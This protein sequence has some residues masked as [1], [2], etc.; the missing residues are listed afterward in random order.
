MKAL[1]L[2]AALAALAL[3]VAC[4]KAAPEEAE[5][6]AA[7][8]VEV[9]VARLGTIT[10]YVRATGTIDPDPLEHFTP[11]ADQRDGQRVD[12]DLEGQ[13]DDAVGVRADERRGPAGGTRRRGN[14]LDDEATGHEFADQCPDRAPRQSCPGNELRTRQGPCCR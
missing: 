7:V 4:H 13:D 10:S 8:P 11:Q 5:T 14:L 9:A 12:L 6:T 2:S 1:G 3:A